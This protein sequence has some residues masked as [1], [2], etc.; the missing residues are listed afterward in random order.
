[1]SKKNKKKS[2]FIVFRKIEGSWMILLLRYMKNY[3]IPKGETE[4]NEDS[5]TGAVRELSEEAS[6]T[7]FYEPSPGLSATF[8]NLTVFLC[9][10]DQPGEIRANPETGIF[11]HHQLLWVQPEIASSITNN[12]I[13]KAVDWALE[14]F[15][16]IKEVTNEV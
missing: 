1:M 15:P 8:D 13:K 11:E 4:K 12:R 14:A 10:T 16:D 3:D 5:Y 6:I 7:N 2:G 9:V